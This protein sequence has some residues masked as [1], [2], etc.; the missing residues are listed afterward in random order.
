MQ[1]LEKLSQKI[2]MFRGGVLKRSKPKLSCSTKEE[3]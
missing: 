3:D 2:E 1:E